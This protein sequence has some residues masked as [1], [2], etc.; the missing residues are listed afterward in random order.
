V[1][2]LLQ[3][4]PLFMVL[5]GLPAAV[6]TMLV[7]RGKRTTP[8]DQ[9]YYETLIDR[10]WASE[11]RVRTDLE[12]E[13]GRREQ[14]EA[15]L[16]KERERAGLLVAELQK[17]L[18]DCKA[19]IAILEHD[20]AAARREALEAERETGALRRALRKLQGGNASA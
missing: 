6:V 3:Y 14:L 9:G 20:L 4:V 16:E 12:K 10:S 15:E 5:I 18:D 8:K 7:Y 19:K 13:H 2:E 11:A 17:K 1:D